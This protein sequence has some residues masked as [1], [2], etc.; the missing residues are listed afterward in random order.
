MT[1]VI[2]LVDGE[3]HPAAVRAA[4]EALRS[5]GN[6]IAGAVFCG[7]TE[8]VDVSKLDEVYGIEVLQ[9]GDL[10]RVLTQALERWRPHV[11]IDLTDEPILSPAQRFEL[12]S[13]SLAA[14]VSYRGADFEFSAR[15]FE[16]IVTKPSIR[17]FAS[18]KRTGKT[19]VA[20][21]LARHAA[22]Q[23]HSPLIVA[24]GRG[25][26]NP[27]R[28]IEAG[29]RLDAALLL[30]WT[31]A[32]HHAGS[33]YVEDAMTSGVT[34]IGCVRVGG[35][36]AGA[37]VY[38][39]A[40]D[41]ARMAEERN[42]DLV[43]FEGSGASFP[44]VAVD[45]GVLCL[46]ASLAPADVNSY[47]GT[48]RL[49]LADLVVVTM[50]E[51]GPAAAQL[52]AEIHRTVPDL[53]VIRVAFRPEPLS[54]VKGRKAFYCC[55]APTDAGPILTD[56]LERVHGCEIVGMTHRLSDR[57]VLRRELD[58]APPHDVVLTELKAGAV[59][60]VVRESVA[61]GTDVVFVNNVPVGGDIEEAFD[62]VIALAN[63]RAE[64]D[65]AASGSGA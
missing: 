11:V 62:R 5:E 42:E 45:A 64:T 12:A 30:E 49:L 19:A 13:H 56:H 40:L 6:E 26:P 7:G 23:E 43:I 61:R 39:N 55:T 25:G 29:T 16:R 35:G 8:K 36:L 33:D 15:T 46:P 52:E 28:L 14:G 9:D 60:V 47:L 44:E 34:T 3:H 27:P 59:D 20:S 50:A 2:V 65:P 63:K 54:E 48:Y 51:E 41:A 4:L 38:S 58:H 53:D 22:A 10:V 21:A 37:T 32:G 1:K 24:V 57:A 18:G 17:V 31:G